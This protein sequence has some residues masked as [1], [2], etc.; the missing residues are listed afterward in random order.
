MLEILIIGHG[1]IA[2]HVAHRVRKIDGAR[3]AYVVCRENRAPAARDA[4]GDD[5]LAINTI[6]QCP[7]KP[8]LAIDCA[9][10]QALREH[11]AA[12]LGNGIDLMTISAGALADDGLAETLDA[13]A[14]ESGARLHLL[15]G[16]VGGIDA[17]TAART[18]GLDHVVYRGRKPPRGWEG[19]P[20]EQALDL[21]GL[22]AAAC[23]FR[24]TAR[25]AARLYP[26]NA[27][28][29][30]TIALAGLGLDRTHVELFADP[31][32]SKNVHEIEA[33]GAFGH[34]HL[35]LSGNA[36]PGN[37]KSSA[38]TAMSIVRAVQSRLQ[39]WT[40]G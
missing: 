11:G 16:A 21:D 20:A 8:G 1:A 25:D 31:T 30:A 6:D 22:Q 18:E 9:G 17:L 28:V 13:A 3:L 14:T 2:S 29:A 39:V 19:S 33:E 37:P 27:N 32:L 15:S 7:V 4:L 38:L 24:G 26:K 36:L 12:I 5:V 10:H 34:L 23:H 35:T 40:M